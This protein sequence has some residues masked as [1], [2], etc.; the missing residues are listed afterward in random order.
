VISEVIKEIREENKLSQ[1]QFAK[2]I[3]VTQQV[4]AKWE[5]GKCLPNSNSLVAI[6]RQFG[7]TP[8][9]ILEIEN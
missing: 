3:G 7:V 8:N 4:V 5:S 1:E 6:Y 2:L 9:E